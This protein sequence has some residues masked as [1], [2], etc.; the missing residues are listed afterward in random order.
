MKFRNKGRKIYKTKEKNYYGKT[1]FGKFMSGALTVLLVGGIG[2]L[3]YSVA[4]PLVNYTKKRGDDAPSSAE[5]TL[6]TRADST[7]A[8]AAELSLPENTNAESFKAL[9]LSPMDL[10]DSASL[11]TALPS[12]NYIVGYEYISVP[13][14]ITGGQI[15]YSSTVTEAQLS[16]AVQSS[17][18]LSEITSAIRSAGYIPCAE[19]SLLEDHIAPCT[20]ADM[21]YVTADD[22]S[23]WID[24]SGSHWLSPFS[25]RT[26]E[27]L[28]AIC[29]EI[30][31]ADFE[32]AVI[33]DVK[34]PAF[35]SNDK[36]YIGDSV[37]SADRY[38]SLTSIA[39][40]LY[41]RML[42][43]GTTMLLEVSAYDILT[44]NC[45]V[46][47]P[48][49]LEASTIVLDIDFDEIGEAVTCGGTTY[50]FT[51]TPAEK[52]E[53]LIGLVQYKLS[54]F[55]VAVRFSGDTLSHNELVMAKES[56]SGY[57]YTSFVIG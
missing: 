44:E 27:Y 39:N 55:N 47:Q 16:G 11:Q 32:R 37:K 6:P 20:Y 2:F 49:L 46:I 34:F 42:A 22:G 40:N 19:I 25:D 35:T 36:D 51:G 53:K 30:A 15:Y 12:V 13:L 54:D 45:D 18:T 31:A 1:P 5:S 41:S 21:S 8:T 14:K 50:E 52:A 56:L 10:R 17:L 24:A 29:D 9:S 57:G 43:G 3:G 38:F 48:M 7:L 4:E 33:S 26:Q 23:R 28:T